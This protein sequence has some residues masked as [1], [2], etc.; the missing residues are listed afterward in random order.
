[1]NKILSKIAFA[2]I[3]LLIG[4]SLVCKS[5]N[6]KYPSHQKLPQRPLMSLGVTTTREE[7]QINILIFNKKIHIPSTIEFPNPLLRK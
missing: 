1:M 3:L 6:A 4:F 2:L 7:N 5:L